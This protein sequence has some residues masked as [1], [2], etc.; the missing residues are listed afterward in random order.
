MV[1]MTRAVTRN[2]AS[3]GVEQEKRHL[4]RK[5]KVLS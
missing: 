5:V 1:M 3:C 2:A 4:F